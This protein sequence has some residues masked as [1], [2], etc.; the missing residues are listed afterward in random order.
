ML[1][2]QCFSCYTVRAAGA[3]S[4]MSESLQRMW[5]H[6]KP[7]AAHR[8]LRQP[9]VSVTNSSDK[10]MQLENALNGMVEFGHDELD[11]QVVDVTSKDVV[12]LLRVSTALGLTPRSEKIDLEKVKAVNASRVKAVMA[13][14]AAPTAISMAKYAKPR[15]APADQWEAL[16]EREKQLDKALMVKPKP[17][18]V[19][20]STQ[21]VLP[22]SAR[23]CYC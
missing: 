22:L 20:L 2:A 5:A 12:A 6:R 3:N 7:D 10:K 14:M 8:L 19:G 11:A 1:S 17:K 21:V 16:L 23:C 4:L 13:E 15:G 9:D 18:H